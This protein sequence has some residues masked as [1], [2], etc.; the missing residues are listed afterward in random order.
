MDQTTRDKV[1]Y[2]MTSSGPRNAARRLAIMRSRPQSQQLAG[3]EFR[4]QMLEQLRIEGIILQQP[5]LPAAMVTPTMA[6]P[7]STPAPHAPTEL[8]LVTQG[9]TPPG[10]PQQTYYIAPWALPTTPQFGQPTQATPPWSPVSHYT[11]QGSQFQVPT[12]MM[13]S[14]VQNASATIPAGVTGQPLDPTQ[15]NRDTAL[16]RNKKSR[17]RRDSSSGSSRD[18]STSRDRRKRHKKSSKRRR[19]SNS[20]S[21]SGGHPRLS[22]EQQEAEYR[23]MLRRIADEAELERFRQQA[24]MTELEQLFGGDIGEWLNQVNQKLS[25]IGHN[26]NEVNQKI[27]SIGQSIA[28]VDRNVTELGRNQRVAA[29]EARQQSENILQ[30]SRDQ[31][32]QVQAGLDNLRTTAESARI[33]LAGYHDEMRRV[34]GA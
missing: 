20:S 14:G 31:A 19:H 11:Y 15:G 16:S 26:I 22:L 27:T 12:Q 10:H 13:A 1:E 18:R 25:V 8:P 28:G 5:T 30:R 23:A 9:T 7:T 6:P 3:D 21:D 33:Q 2:Y 17:R 4:Q 32:A 24:K 34:G 29:D